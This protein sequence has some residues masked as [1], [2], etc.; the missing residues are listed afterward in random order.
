MT[1]SGLALIVAALLVLT[2][3]FIKSRSPDQPARVQAQE[4]LQTLQLHDAALSRAALMTR[5]GLL[6]HYDSIPD[7]RE[8]LSRELRT[9]ERA[10]QELARDGT[11]AL[12]QHTQTL[13]DALQRKQRLVDD[14]TS[15]N[16]ILRNSTTYFAHLVEGLG[17]NGGSGPAATRALADAHVLMRLVH[18]PESVLH[19]EAEQARAALT[20]A[21]FDEDTAGPLSAH[22]ALIVDLLPRVDQELREVTSIPVAAYVDA[23]QQE[24]LRSA[25]VAERRAQQYR[26]LLYGSAIVLLVYLLRVFARLRSHARELRQKEIQLIQANK[27]TALG[28][29]VSSVAHEINNPNQVVLINAG[30]LAS[31]WDDVVDALDAR[32]GDGNGPRIAGL[33]YAEMRD[34]LPRLARETEEGARRIE[35]IVADLKDFARPGTRAH[36]LFHL[37]D[38][39]GRAVRLLS[40]SIQKRTDAFCVRLAD[41]LPL[42]RG[43]PQQVEQV[44]VNLVV[45]A[46]E[47]LPHR[48]AA[49]TVATAHDAERHELIL[50]VE[51]QGMGIQP[52]HLPRLGEAFFTTKEANGGTGLGIAIASSLVRLHH[53][54]LSF[55]SQPGKGTSACVRL[56]LPADTRQPALETT[57]SS[58]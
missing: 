6:A 57:T 34:T 35:Q 20:G 23:L 3:L 13:A 21:Q 12:I 36:E 39:V 18:A 54:R 38:V 51:D 1:R 42:A 11:D 15:D 50:T 56:P 17:R 53:G 47:A 58:P 14:F 32:G 16:A 4:A 2:Y 45:N 46:L 30:V 41:T 33:P 10:I 19:D 8:D 37:N 48:H 40:Y 26:L 31:A 28:T 55:A 5:A 43:N 29:L 22:A 49:V 52:D 44:A 9:L 24:L 25:S 7:I 27:M